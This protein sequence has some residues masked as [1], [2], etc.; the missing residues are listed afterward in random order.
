VLLLLLLASGLVLPAG[1]LLAA[2]LVTVRR[3]DSRMSDVL[4][5]QA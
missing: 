2:S 5:Q 3:Q 4:H 1:V